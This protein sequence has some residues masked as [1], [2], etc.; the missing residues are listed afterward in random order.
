MSIEINS[1]IKQIIRQST[2]LNSSVTT[3]LESTCRERLCPVDDLYSMGHLS[4][5]F[6]CNIQTFHVGDKISRMIRCTCFN[7]DY[8]LGSNIHYT[9]GRFLFNQSCII[10]Q[11]RTL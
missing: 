11:V 4:K 2:Y 8:Q 1:F 3:T 10:G 7:R 9:M 5:Y 6:S